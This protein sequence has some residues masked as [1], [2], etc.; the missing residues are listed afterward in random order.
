MK[1]YRNMVLAAASLLVLSACDSGLSEV[2][3]GDELMGLTASL[4]AL[5]TRTVVATTC[6]VP[7]DSTR[8]LMLEFHAGLASSLGPSPALA[9]A[10]RRAVAR[11][12]KDVAAAVAFGKIRPSVATQTKS[13]A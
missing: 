10:Q 3:S 2:R 1:K 11:G 6:P 9:R 12:P 4:L 5:G 13:V 7:D 8:R